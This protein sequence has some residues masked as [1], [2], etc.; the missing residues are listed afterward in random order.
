MVHLLQLLRLL[1][2][3]FEFLFKVYPVK[4]IFV[5]FQ[6]LHFEEAHCLLHNLRSP[7]LEF[8]LF[9]SVNLFDECQV[10]LFDKSVMLLIQDLL[11]FVELENGRFDP[12]H[13]AGSPADD[14]SDGW[15]SS[16]DNKAWVSLLIG[17]LP[18]LKQRS[19][20]VKLLLVVVEH[21]GVLLLQF[22]GDL[23]QSRDILEVI[24][25][26][27]GA[28]RRPQI[29]ECIVN[30]LYGIVFDCHLGLLEVVY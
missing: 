9:V 2:Q 27:E 20:V 30:Q 1:Y 15:F 13:D 22:F 5:F 16:G 4:S 21:I 25:K 19:V 7:L 10:L 28:L 6:Y 11:I 23:V 3:N 12:L 8:G 26:V 29:F 18:L 14:P 17:F 24:K